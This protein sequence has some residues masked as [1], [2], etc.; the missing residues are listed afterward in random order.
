MKEG[1]IMMAGIRLLTA[2][3]DKNQQADVEKQMAE[4]EKQQVTST[5]PVVLGNIDDELILNG[6]VMCDEALVRKI[7]VPCTG[8]VKGVTAEVG[9]RVNKGQ[10][11]ATVYSE[12]A[13]DYIKSL[14]DAE[15]ELRL[16]QREYDMQVDMHS[17]GMASD[18]ELTEARER[19]HMAKAEYTRLQDVA[20]IN[21]YS[22]QSEAKLIAPISGYVINKN[23]YN[24]SYVSEDNNNEAAIEIADL[25][26]VW[27][28]ADVYESDIAKVHQGA[29]AT[30]TMMAYPDMK[31]KGK[32]DKIY[33]VLDSES[34]TLKLRIVLDNPEGNLKPGMFAC[35]H[36]SMS[37][38]SQ[39]MPV[40]PSSAVIFDGG[41]NYVM[42][43]TGKDI[44]ERRE[45]DIA[46]ESTGYSF[47]KSGVNIGEKVVTKNA[48][49]YFNA[50]TSHE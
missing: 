43:A 41:H 14:N 44:Y 24:D 20:A 3:N 7:F 16:A 42:V 6:D 11:L 34:K 38:H 30:I 22:H 9:D 50:D 8:R 36:V 29:S 5:E 18:K 35:V 23:I 13:A 25:R 1:V 32:V 10:L 47:L 21:G 40:V 15:T 49:L 27:V 39:K 12:G 19:V 17:A 28:I 46:H 37:D 31:Y 26:T 48:L 45:V 4:I 2:C 33:S